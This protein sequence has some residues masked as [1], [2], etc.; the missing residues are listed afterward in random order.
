MQRWLVAVA[1]AVLVSCGSSSSSN[2]TY[3]GGIKGTPPSGSAGFAF[4]PVDGAAL[5]VNPTSCTIQ[6]VGTAHVA[7]LLLGFS[8]FSGMCSFV[9]QHGVGCLDGGKASAT[10]VGIAIFH[11]DAVSASAIAPGTYTMNAQV[12]AGATGLIVT[13]GSVTVTNAT[14]VD[15]GPAPTAISGT[16]TITSASAAEVTGS[17]NL[18]WAGGAFSGPFDLVGCSASVDVCGLANGT[19]T[20]SGCL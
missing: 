5:T 4:T 7:G 6:G 2:P 13:E 1:T 19:A 11:A 12:P 9:Q 20:C 10:S 3:N 15:S 17:V 8:S 16:V 18:T 14:C